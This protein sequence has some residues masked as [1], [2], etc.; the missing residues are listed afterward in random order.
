M[1]ENGS[2][3]R[4][5]KRF[6]AEETEEEGNIEVMETFD[7]PA[8][9]DNL[10]QPLEALRAQKDNLTLP[11]QAKAPF[12]PSALYPQPAPAA[13]RLPAADMA[14]AAIEKQSLQAYTSLLMQYWSMWSLPTM[15]CPPYMNPQLLKAL[16]IQQQQQQYLKVKSDLLATSDCES[17]GDRSSPNSTIVSSPGSESEH[18]FN[19][20][21]ALD[22]SSKQ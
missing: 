20:D 2:F 11:V 16:Q 10:P 22:L 19:Q 3:L 14:A 13:Y 15:V 5:R 21:H 8:V 6:K 18:I 9:I 4:R 12:S 7:Q 17:I 1:F